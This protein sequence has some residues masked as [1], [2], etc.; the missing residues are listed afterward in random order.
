MK[1]AKPFKTEPISPNRWS[2]SLQTTIADRQSKEG[3]HT[4]E[5]YTLLQANDAV[6][7]P[8]KQI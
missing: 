7:A 6:Y 3:F 8:V 4:D 5:A 1:E 2:T